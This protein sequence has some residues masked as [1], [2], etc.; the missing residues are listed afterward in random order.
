MKFNVNLKMY[1]YK[2][3]TE[4]DTLIN[5]REHFTKSLKYTD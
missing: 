1:I 4:C 3:I 2:K 5:S